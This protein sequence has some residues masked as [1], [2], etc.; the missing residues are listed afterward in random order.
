MKWNFTEPTEGS[1]IFVG[2]D[3]LGNWAP[4]NHKQIRGHNLLWHNQL[5]S[6]LTEVSDPAT[7]AEILAFYL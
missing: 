2:A 6:W 5:P 3:W 1:F 4:A 7:M